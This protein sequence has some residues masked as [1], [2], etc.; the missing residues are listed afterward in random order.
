M[1][2]SINLRKGEPSG[3]YKNNKLV[4]VSLHKLFNTDG[5]LE[6]VPGLRA[7]YSLTACR[8]LYENI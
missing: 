8:K 4:G 5:L 2:D 3:R 6:S 7:T 1:V